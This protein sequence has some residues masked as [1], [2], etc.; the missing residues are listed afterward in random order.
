MMNLASAKGDCVRARRLALVL[1]TAL[2]TGL[3]MPALAQDIASPL[4]PRVTV[5][6]NGVELATGQFMSSQTILSIGP[7]GRGGL[8]YERF[9]GGIRAGSNWDVRLSIPQNG[10]VVAT[11]YGQSYKFKATGSGYES[12][13][14]KGA[15]LSLPAGN[16]YTLTTPSGIKVVYDSS[17]VGFSTVNG[18]WQQEAESFARATSIAY[19]DGYQEVLRYTK[20]DI[21][22]QNY[23]SCPQQYRVI[24]ARPK[25]IVN[26][27]GYHLHF[28]YGNNILT[29]YDPQT[30][31]GLN[32]QAINNNV[33]YC[34]PSALSC[35]TLSMNW[36]KMEFS[37]NGT[38]SPGGK[39]FTYSNL[40]TTIT[41]S[42]G[43]GTT[44][45]VNK[46]FGQNPYLK[47]VS[48]I[49]NKGGTWTY[50]YSVVGNV[51]TLIRTDPAGATRKYISDVAKGVVT[52]F[53]NEFGKVTTYEYDSVGRMTSVTYPEGNKNAFAYDANGNLV[54]SRLISK[55]PG[56]PADAVTSASYPCSSEATCDKPAWTRDAR[57]N[58]TDLTYDSVT[59]NVLTIAKPAAASGGVRPVTT[60]GYSVA[61]GVQLLTST[62]ACQTLA[63]CAGSADEVKTTIG[64][65]ANLLPTTETKAAGNGSLSATSTTSY[66]NV[67]N[68]V[69]MDGPLPG[70]DDTTLRLYD[71]DRALIADMSPDPDGSG[72]RKRVAHRYTYDANGL[73]TSAELGTVPS[74][75]TDWSGFATSQT[76]QTAYDGN[77]RKAT[78]TVI[79]GGGAQQLVQYSYDSIG[80]LDCRAV[81]MNP[82]AYG[83]LPASACTPGTAGG[84]GPD[85]ITKNGYDSASR[86]LKVTSGYG[87]ADASDDV[88]TTY[89]DNGRTASLTDANGN[90]TSYAYDGLDRLSLTTFP[91]PTTG[92]G[93]SN[94][95][96]YEQLGYDGGSNIISRRLRDGQTITYGYDNRNQMVS[97][98]TP[99]AAPSW[100]VSYAYDLLGRVTS[101]LGDGWAGNNFGYDALGRQVTEGHYNAT[102]YHTYDLAGRQTRLTW[103][104]GFYVD[105]DYD[106]ADNMTAIRENGATSGAGVL[107]TYGYDDLGRR[108]SITRG[109]GTTTTYGYDPL[110]QLSSLAQ[111]LAGGAYDFTNSFTYNPAGQI[112]TAT[113]SND[114]Y[115]WNGHYNVDRPYTV[116]GLNQATAAGPASLGYDARG[117]LTSSAGSAYGYTA[118]DELVSAPGASLL[119]EPGGR[120]LLQAYNAS[121]GAD[122]RFAWSGGQ[123]IAEINAATWTISRRYVP[124]ASADEPVVWYEGS[125]TGDRRWLHA[126]E[127]GSVVAATDGAGNAIGINSYDEYGIPGPANIGRFQYTGQAW[128]PDIGMYYYKARIYSPSLGRFMQTDQIGYADGMNWY[129]Y[130]HGDPVNE[131][132]PDGQ[133]G[134]TAGGYTTTGGYATNSINWHATTNS[135]LMICPDGT[136]QFSCDGHGAPP[137][138]IV[139]GHRI[140]GGFG[141]MWGSWSGSMAQQAGPCTL[142]QP[143]CSVGR[144]IWE[145]SLAALQYNKKRGEEYVKKCYAGASQVEIEDVAAGAK[146]GL[147]KGARNGFVKGAIMGAPEGPEAA[148]ALGGARATLEGGTG[149]VTGGAKGAVKAACDKGNQ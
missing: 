26:S 104:D 139:N 148:A 95:S 36:P 7:N 115:A 6:E 67:G 90:K 129:G 41:I 29:G 114:A 74:M 136:S 116:N 105:Y 64:Y 77:A 87:T 103:S 2:C 94:P 79:A 20:R 123:M 1:S 85:R 72:P 91:S 132:D 73:R 14:G 21:C 137:E 55:T 16:L 118:E 133:S 38:V 126:D 122:T 102:T 112:W 82:A 96:D 31:G 149:M 69:S 80:R 121:T 107:A 43:D 138:I 76:V 131:T 18:V 47:P 32:I 145:N 50:S 110:S 130:V 84:N 56:T 46:P 140:F 117:N 22:T 58:Q 146:K 98:I 86:L 23:A 28:N 113:R 92:A 141:A 25:S 40:G 44:K 144:W 62:S 53:T 68:P 19:P 109:N 93:A 101:T 111:D 39:F 89:T 45:T 97:K 65:N 42:N 142:G 88:S 66:D 71:A 70:S 100:D 147:V 135:P 61:G 78:D 34:D 30:T 59:G 10:T 128:L 15:K 4:P 35:S 120:Q 54:E 48:S 75:A 106:A 125:G 134:Q 143:D 63:S 124:G 3:A 49:V 83:S 37:G 119:Y 108:A 12:Q 60:Y 8:S 9:F 57:G 17:L 127:R 24:S 99:G 52:S 11:L 5:D 81:R 13:D 33:E 27:N 51:A